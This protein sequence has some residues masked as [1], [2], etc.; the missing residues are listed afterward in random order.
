MK[1]E[2][3]KL[4]WTGTE[5]A[6]RAK[7]DERKIRMAQRLRTE[8]PVTLNWIGAEVHMGTWIH[9]AN[10]LQIAKDKNESNQHG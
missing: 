6:Q 9:I 10:R 5:L 3:D 1:E 2:L 8:T 4:G 7:G